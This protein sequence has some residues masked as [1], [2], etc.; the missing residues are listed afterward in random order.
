MRSRT[1]VGDLVGFSRTAQVM[2]RADMENFLPD[3][4]P[5]HTNL[6]V[7]VSQGSIKMIGGNLSDSTRVVDIRT[8][9]QGRIDPDEQYFFVLQ[10]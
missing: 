1:K 8:D 5:S 4:F 6:V 3:K 10:R 9:A 7:G 2:N